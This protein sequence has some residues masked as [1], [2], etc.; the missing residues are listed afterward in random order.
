MDNDGD[1]DE[2]DGDDDEE[3]EE[4]EEDECGRRTIW[5]GF[6]FKISGLS[7]LERSNW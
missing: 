7:R 4:E 5:T 2:D 1:D 6:D 3:E